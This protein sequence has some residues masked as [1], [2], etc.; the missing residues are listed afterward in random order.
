MRRLLRIPMLYSNGLT[1]LQKAKEAVKAI[2][3]SPLGLLES[4]EFGAKLK[5][6][7]MNNPIFAKKLE[8]IFLPSNVVILALLALSSYIFILGPGVHPSF[9]TV[10]WFAVFSSWC[11]VVIDV[12]K[13]N[14][15]DPD[16]H[17][18]IS[19]RATIVSIVIPLI[20]MRTVGIPPILE[21]V[22]ITFMIMS[23]LMYAIRSKWKIS[24]HVCTYTAMSTIMTMFSMWCA[25]LFLLIPVLSWSRIKLKAHT[26]TQVFVGSLVG[27]IIPYTF[28][29]LLPMF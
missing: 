14:I 19:L 15:D 13:N 7:S 9:M 20:L 3:R 6:R 24:G 17:N 16:K 10:L 5:L 28:A 12:I 25:P 8:G 23:P 26:A 22:V 11:F 4:A 27:F 21:Y 2:V 1:K 18:I 29:F